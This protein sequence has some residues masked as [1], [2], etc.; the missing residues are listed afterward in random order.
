[1]LAKFLLCQTPGGWC[2]MTGGGNSVGH[3]SFYN[4]CLGI[5]IFHEWNEIYMSH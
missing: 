3:E 1:L 5:C 4:D 2:I